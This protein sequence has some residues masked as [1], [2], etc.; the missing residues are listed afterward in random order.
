MNHT[1]NLEN[2]NQLKENAIINKHIY[3]K[4]QI[5]KKTRAEFSI[6]LLNQPNVVSYCGN[7]SREMERNSQK[8]E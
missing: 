1:Q 2:K 4:K 5:K 7:N 3:K 6:I 8:V